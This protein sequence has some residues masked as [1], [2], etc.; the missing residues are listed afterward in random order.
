MFHLNRWNQFQLHVDNFDSYSETDKV[1]LKQK[2]QLVFNQIKKNDILNIYGENP[3]SSSQL[4]DILK[5]TKN[6]HI[7]TRIWMSQWIDQ[8]DET[9]IEY[10]VDELVIWCPDITKESFNL[11]SGTEYFDIFY[12]NRILQY[13]TFG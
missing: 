7:F 8:I 10:F 1:Q 3:M 5:Y 4:M 12:S 11:V 13:G 9:D 2:S 6:N